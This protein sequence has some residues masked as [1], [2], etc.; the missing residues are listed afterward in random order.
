MNS[1]EDSIPGKK[2][3][4]IAQAQV[5]KLE[6]NLK[7]LDRRNTTLEVDLT[8]AEDALK[9]ARAQL[10]SQVALVKVICEEAQFLGVKLC[11]NSVFEVAAAQQFPH[12]L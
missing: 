3:C 11:L 10:E 12:S 7:K 1:F 2:K 9:D 4:S 8:A 5:W 6:V